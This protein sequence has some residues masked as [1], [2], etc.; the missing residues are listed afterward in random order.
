[1]LFY[2]WLFLMDKINTIFQINICLCLEY[3]LSLLNLY[4]R[5]QAL[6]RS[7]LS[8]II[9]MLYKMLIRGCLFYG[10]LFLSIFWQPYT[11]KN[12]SINFFFLSN[13][14]PFVSHKHNICKLECHFSSHFSWLFYYRSKSNFFIQ[15]FK[16]LQRQ[17][18]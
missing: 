18:K 11:F 14:K 17:I 6:L 8:G 1:M 3:V 10:N 15:I 5:K 16:C 2:R 7:N 13:D 12:P 9:Q 4:K